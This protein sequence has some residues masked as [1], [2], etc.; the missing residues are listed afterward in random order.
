VID[1]EA[2]R[3]EFVEAKQTAQSRA[4][5]AL[6]G[7]SV[8]SDVCRYCGRFWQQRAGSQLDGHAACIVPND[9]KRKIGELLRSPLVTYASIA[10]ELGVTQGIVY[11]WAITA[12]IVGPTTHK[13]R[14]KN[15][16]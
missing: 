13:L 8:P 10:K 16:R 1:G 3:S 5:W 2:L 9:F 11:S 6:D 14:R 12:G 15:R 7:P 4:V